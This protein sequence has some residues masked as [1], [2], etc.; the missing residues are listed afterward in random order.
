MADEELLRLRANLRAEFRKR[1]LADSVGTIGESLA[2]EFFRKNSGLPKLQLAPTGTKNVD[3]LSRNGDRYSIKTVCEGSK[4]GTIYP[5]RDNRN[6]QLFEFMLVLKLAEDWSLQAVHQL[7]WEQFVEIRSW[8]KRMNAWYIAYNRT[9]LAAGIPIVE[10][11][12][13][14][15][16]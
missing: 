8:D 4:T 15:D 14:S 3:A 1:R 16:A 13:P 11:A 12:S 2:M 7:S 9:K 10:H 5:E 6:K